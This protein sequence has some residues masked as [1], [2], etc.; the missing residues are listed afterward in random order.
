MVS[1]S[2]GMRKDEAILT[3]WYEGLSA[4]LRGPNETAEN[5]SLTS[6]LA[7]IWTRASLKTKKKSQ[8]FDH[9]VCAS[10]F[11][12]CRDWRNWFSVFVSILSLQLNRETRSV[13]EEKSLGNPEWWRVRIR[14]GL[15]RN[16]GTWGEVVGLGRWCTEE[17]RQLMKP[18]PQRAAGKL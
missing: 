16:S 18:F 10:S 12:T 6:I 13:W 17:V 5:K 4:R 14:A 15:W 8:P 7:E 3:C 1:D 9:D 2:G 11:A